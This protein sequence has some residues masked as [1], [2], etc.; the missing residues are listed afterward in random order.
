MLPFYGYNRLTSGYKL[1]QRPQHAGYDV[2][3]YAPGAAVPCDSVVRALADGSIGQSTMVVSQRDRTW[4]WGHFVRL[5]TADGQY[6]VYSCHLARRLVQ[7]GAAVKKGDAIGIMGNTGKSEGAH[8]GK[9]N[10]ML[11]QWRQ[12]A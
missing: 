5:D 10:I 3:S 8:Y 4:E 7:P 6:W 2:V 11:S 12:A 9:K 1:P